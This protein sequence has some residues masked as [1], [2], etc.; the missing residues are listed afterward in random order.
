MSRS[1]S[2]ATHLG[3]CVACV[4]KEGADNIYSCTQKAPA[5]WLC[6]IGRMVIP[7]HT[8]TY[9]SLQA[10]QFR[11]TCPSRCDLRVTLRLRTPH[12]LPT[13][14]LYWA[15]S[16]RDMHASKQGCSAECAYGNYTNMGVAI[17]KRGVYRIDLRCPQP[18]VAEDPS[19]RASVMWSRHMHFVAI[20]DR[21]AV[22]TDTNKVH[23]LLIMPGERTHARFQYNCA[24]LFDPLTHTYPSLYVGFDDYWRARRKGVVCINAVKSPEYRAISTTDLVLSPSAHARHQVERVVLEAIRLNASA[25]ADRVDH[26][27]QLCGASSS[28]SKR[29]KT[30]RRRRTSG[31]TRKHWPASQTR[32]LKRWPLLVYCVKPDC[33]AASRLLFLLDELGF[34]NVY[35]MPGGI[36]EARRQFATIDATHLPPRAEEE[37]GKK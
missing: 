24:P 8:E 31:D 25:E 11:E 30:L 10:R 6:S 12:A 36:V 29:S 18:Y 14:I 3:V 27:L 20:D 17:A 34:H 32:M 23:T 35:Y 16:P 21:D 22:D 26:V 37:S 9:R 13:R 1:D 4:K 7:S 15:A 19:T 28:S 2:Q 5:K 33:H